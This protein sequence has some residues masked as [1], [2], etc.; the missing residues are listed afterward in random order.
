M[1]DG[2]I[3][4]QL[5]NRVADFIAC[6]LA[7]IYNA[8]TVQESWPAVW[9]VESVTPIPKKPIPELP[10]DTRN[11]SC[12]RPFSKVYESFVMSWLTRN[13]KLR[14]N[15]YGGVKGCGTEHILLQIWQDIL[16]GLDDSRAGV[17]LSPINYLKAFNQ[18]D[19][20]GCLQSLKAKG[21]CQE[22]L[23]IIDSFL[24]GRQMSVKVG[25][26]CSQLRPVL[27]G[28][29]QG[30]SPRSVPFQLHNR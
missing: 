21:V 10:N 20:A 29:P 12:T 13:C 6:P 28:V 26:C 23:N 4:P 8:I 7:S 15:Q 25:N 2:D 3:L 1:V 11:I 19:F 5:V 27:V 9:K 30:F 22:L 18:L 24:T 16:E 17:L 14:P